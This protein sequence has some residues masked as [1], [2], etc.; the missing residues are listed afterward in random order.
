MTG[1]QTCALPISC[2]FTTPRLTGSVLG[3]NF[4]KTYSE[5]GDWF[6][7]MGWGTDDYNVHYKHWLHWLSDSEVPTAITDGDYSIWNHDTADNSGVRGLEIPFTLPSGNVAF[8]EDSLY[9]EY[10]V[11][12]DNRLLRAGPTVRL[13]SRSGPKAYLLDGTPETPNHGPGGDESG[14]LDSP[15]PPGRTFTYSSYEIGR[16]HV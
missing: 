12:P 13:G 16:A 15:L 9:V 4:Y 11:F 1:V 3:M 7:Q 6:D 5:Y 2:L 10:R 14:N 8:G